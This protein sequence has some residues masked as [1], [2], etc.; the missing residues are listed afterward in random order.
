MGD[1]LK[2]DEGKIEWDAQQKGFVNERL[3]C[4]YRAVIRR[5]TKKEEGDH[6]IIDGCSNFRHNQRCQL[7]RCK[8][9]TT[10]QR[11]ILSKLRVVNNLPRDARGAHVANAL[12]VDAGIR[13]SKVYAKRVLGDATGLTKAAFREEF[14]K[15]DC[16]I[17]YP[18]A[19]PQMRLA[20]PR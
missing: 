16:L 18:T 9:T 10:V 12:S 3:C 19:I 17:N 13:V 15:I 20:L 8:R 14:T 1:K 7:R 6:Y 2:L 11:R 4:S 5:V